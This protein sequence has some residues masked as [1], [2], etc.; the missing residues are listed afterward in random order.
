[1]IHPIELCV[2][3]LLNG[4]R[5]IKLMNI[6][7]ALTSIIF[8]VEKPSENKL[9][10]LSS[11][12]DEKALNSVFSYLF[13][14]VDNQFKPTS[15][16]IS[17]AKDEISKLKLYRETELAIP[18]KLS[19]REGIASKA[20]ISGLS[21]YFKV[22]FLP[23]NIQLAELIVLTMKQS[24]SM[25]QKHL[26][27]TLFKFASENFS[28]IQSLSKKQG[29]N[30]N[31]FKSEA[32]KSINIVFEKFKEV[33]G[34]DQAIFIFKQLFDFVKE[35]YPF[36]IVESFVDILPEKYFDEQKTF[37]LS[38]SVLNKRVKEAIK[39]NKDKLATSEKL[40]QELITKSDLIENQIKDLEN[41]KR[42]M[43]N[44][45]EDQKELELSLK[46]EKDR[47]LSI[48]SSMGEGL[49]VLDEN[50]K[51]ELMNA[52][53][54]QLLEVKSSEVL[55]RHWSEI[56]TSYE[57]D[58]EI[59]YEERSTI[60]SFNTGKI[61]F[62]NLEDNHYYSPKSGKKFP[63]TSTTTPLF[64]DNMATGTIKVFRDATSDQLS[65]QH[66]EEE[67]A[68]RTQELS[69]EKTK[70]VSSI[71]SIVRAYIFIDPEGKIVLV[72]HLLSDYLGEIDGP[73]SLEKVQEKIGTTFDIISAFKKALNQKITTI[74]DEIEIE[75]KYFDIFINPVLKDDGLLGVLIMFGD[76]TEEKVLDRS[77]DEFFSIASH[78]L[79]TPL[80]A[81]RGNTSMIL[82]YYQ[83][84]IKD[85]ELKLM[86]TD[87]HDAS[88]RLIAIVNDFLDL[89]RLEQGKIVYKLVDFK[90][91]DTVLYIVKELESTANEKK[92]TLEAKIDEQ[93]IVTADADKLKQVLF[94]I[95]GNSIKFTEKGGVTIDSV[96]KDNIAEVRITDT[97]QG[98]PVANQALLF[99]KFQQ[100]GKSTITR[101]GAKGT[102]LGLYISK[103]MI[104]A[105]GGKIELESSVEGKGSVFMF[106]LPIVKT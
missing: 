84:Q 96:I 23:Q 34:A 29:I 27:N 52:A 24:E 68:M 4:R 47:I 25:S 63:I 1:M 65:K 99:R 78:E 40:Y 19:I 94:N 21:P 104:E 26:G 46:Q 2:K 60:I 36:D 105:M 57:E 33:L 69:D 85:P 71:E 103:L 97:G 3:K 35:I 9:L 59:P 16:R 7:T 10:S 49:F 100:A 42:A 48:I 76:I 101:D 55:G 87:M 14:K 13:S 86:I 106:T 77:K 80:T 102:G 32:S 70:L 43:T 58:K 88:L 56:V 82:E 17:V 89:S 11:D 37:A 28:H 98:V 22:I 54:E 41:S 72:N 81:I 95:V 92:I 83:E 51:I 30:L 15:D 12:S 91:K 38:E 31:D 45:L 5:Y 50:H 39:E 62:T 64:K 75:T 18:D 66:I 93:I 73:W 44:I 79:R 90:L 53:A 8:P 67:V 61:L 20:L 6:I 74:V